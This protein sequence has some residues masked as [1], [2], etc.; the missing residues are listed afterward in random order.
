MLKNDYT[1]DSRSRSHRFATII[2]F[3]CFPLNIHTIRHTELP[4]KT[5][6]EDEWHSISSLF[7]RST[8][9]M[10]SQCR[11]VAKICYRPYTPHAP[12]PLSPPHN[13]STLKFIRPSSAIYLHFVLNFVSVLCVCVCVCL[14]A[15]IQSTLTMNEISVAEHDLNKLQCPFLFSLPS[16]FYL[17][18]LIFTAFILYIYNLAM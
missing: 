15:R 14:L 3:T 4:S 8:K 1:H 18:T 10:P 9:M 6:I 11:V 2:T 5:E 13:I 16:H 17:T 7:V 12:Y